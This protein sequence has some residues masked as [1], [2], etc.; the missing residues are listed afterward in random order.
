MDKKLI[1]FD[2]DGVLID[3]LSVCFKIANEVNEDL[4]LDEYKGFFDGNMYDA[5]RKN[6]LLRSFH[7]KRN[8]IYDDSVRTLDVPVELKELVKRL[9]D[10]YTLAIVSS[11]GSRSIREVLGKVGIE[12][13]FDDVLGSDVHSSKVIKIKSV[14]ESHDLNSNDALM[15][16][17][18]LG[19]IKEA[20]TAGVESIG[21]L[22]GWHDKENLMRGS[23]YRTV[24]NQFELEKAI[25]NFFQGK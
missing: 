20:K 7:P 11:T 13:C 9:S 5:K 16:T 17:D 24:A 8:E 4:Y 6:G 10:K 22:W 23:P 21:V 12:E 2:F 14:L 19:D 25:E 18:T 1:I 15:V 3:T